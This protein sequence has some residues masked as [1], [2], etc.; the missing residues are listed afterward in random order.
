MSRLE[1]NRS[2]TLLNRAFLEPESDLITGI[3]LRFVI[4]KLKAQI[5]VMNRSSLQK[6]FI[7]LTKEIKITII[8][9]QVQEI[10]CSKENPSDWQQ[11]RIMQGSLVG[12]YVDV[13]SLFFSKL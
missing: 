11:I 12:S 3:G 5:Q 7:K 10:C 13:G 8:N 9:G 1:P 4:I 2:V 6:H